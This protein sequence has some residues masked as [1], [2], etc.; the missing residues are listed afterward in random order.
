PRH[1]IQPGSSSMPSQIPGPRTIAFAIAHFPQLQ[2]PPSRT[3]LRFHFWILTK[4]YFPALARKPQSPIANSKL[5]IAPPRDAI[6]RCLSAIYNLQ[7]RSEEH[8]SELQ[9][10]TNLVCRLLLEKKKHTQT[11]RA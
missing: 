8:T 10:L 11:Y 3:A 1:S 9:S 5:Q 2:P 4:N 7:S 6:A